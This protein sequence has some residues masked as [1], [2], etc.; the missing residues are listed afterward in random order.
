M[1]ISTAERQLQV[2]QSQ[3]HLG[4]TLSNTYT[5]HFLQ[6]L[7]SNTYIT[8]LHVQHHY[9]TQLRAAPPLPLLGPYRPFIPAPDQLTFTFTPLQTALQT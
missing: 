3:T 7:R 1:E 2:D 9:H 6:A 8:L 4:Q 5:K